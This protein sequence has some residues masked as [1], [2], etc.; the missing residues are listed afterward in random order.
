MLENLPKT[1]VGV[2]RF[3]ADPLVCVDFVAMMRWENGEP[4]CFHCK[5]K[6]AYFMPSRKIYRCKNKECKKQFSIKMGTIFEES[7]VSLDKWLMAMWQLANCKNGISSYELGKAI[8][9]TQRTAWF[10][11][12]R[13]RTAMTNGTIEKMSGTVEIDEAFIGGDAK[14]MHRSKRVRFSKPW[15]RNVKDHKTAV[16]G[17]VQRGGKV[18]AQV[19]KGIQAKDVMPV[20]QENIEPNSEVFSDQ[21]AIYRDLYEKYVHATV[22]H[23]MEY[24]RGNVHTNS[25]ENFWSLLKRT[26]KGTYISVSPAHLQKYVEEQMF[27]YNEREGTDQFRFV[28]MLESISGKRLTYN[29]LIGYETGC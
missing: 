11:L 3:F 2:S 7:A 14:N 24:V 18:K 29:Q 19:I 6:G 23:S 28:R 26:I 22:N 10:M 13:I 9:V 12:H 1:F 5:Q 27:R 4:V 25:I 8:G 15:T 21:A 16:F 20:I 17:M